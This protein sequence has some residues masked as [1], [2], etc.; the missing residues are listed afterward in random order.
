MAVLEENLRTWL[1]ADSTIAS[2]VGSR[3]F[4]NTLNNDKGDFIFI[5]QSGS[6]FEDALDDSAGGLP[7]R[8]TYDLDVW[9]E[10]VDISRTLGQRV[11]TYAHL[12]TGTF[13]D[14]TVKRVFAADQ[15][16]DYVPKGDASRDSFHGTFLRLEVIP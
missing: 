6:G 15:D 12:Y 1:L 8:R 5:R 10:D 7:F 13:G 16:E 3:V 14:T 2:Y 9:C 4:I 11:Q